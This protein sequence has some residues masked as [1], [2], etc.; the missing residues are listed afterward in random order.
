MKTAKELNEKIARWKEARKSYRG[1]GDT[2]HEAEMRAIEN[3]LDRLIVEENGVEWG[4]ELT[5][6]TTIDAGVI[7]RTYAGTLNV[8]GAAIWCEQNGVACRFE[9]ARRVL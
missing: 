1:A 6:G 5:P 8:I 4:E 9:D 3:E 2:A 7:R